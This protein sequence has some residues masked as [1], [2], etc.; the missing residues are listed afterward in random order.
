M[1]PF[2]DAH[3]RACTQKTEMSR[4]GSQATAGRRPAATLA[5]H[6]HPL[7]DPHYMMSYYISGKNNC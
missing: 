4:M 7:I 6:S 3:H 5:A 1:A 2:E